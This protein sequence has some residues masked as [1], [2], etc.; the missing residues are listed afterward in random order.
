MLPP[1]QAETFFF[2]FLLCKLRT[3]ETWKKVIWTLGIPYSK[4]ELELKTCQQHLN[5]KSSQ[6][7]FHQ[8]KLMSQ[9]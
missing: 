4:S 8:A 1:K 9:R 2:F 3:A 6:S 7:K 5:N